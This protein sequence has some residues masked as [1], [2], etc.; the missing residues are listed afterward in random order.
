[1]FQEMITTTKG[2]CRCIVDEL[3]SIIEWKECGN[4]GVVQNK[5]HMGSTTRREP[6]DDCQS[7]GKWVKVNGVWK[8]AEKA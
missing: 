2:L 6:C 3:S 8:E 7:N 5:T 4:C 1:M